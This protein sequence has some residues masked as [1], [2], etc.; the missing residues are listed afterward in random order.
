MEACPTGAIQIIDGAARVE[1]SLCR[2]CEACLKTCPQGAILS[3]REPEEAPKPVPVRTPLPV[4]IR[5][6]PVVTRPAG[7]LLPLAGAALAFIG[8]EV[9]PRVAVALLDAWDRRQRRPMQMAPS[10]IDGVRTTASRPP[11]MTDRRAG[12][13]RRRFRRRGRG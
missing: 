5:P 10:P 11:A 1:Q 3:V 7:R 4:P 6:T 2:E 12:R 9:V 8:R 13:W